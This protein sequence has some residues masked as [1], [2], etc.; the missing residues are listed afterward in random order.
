MAISEAQLETWS[1][2][3][4]VTTAKATADSV[5]NAIDSYREWEWSDKL[6]FEVYLQ[7]S[8]KNNTNIRADS[9]V[10]VVAQLNTAF[11]SNLSDE[12]KR[13]LGLPK[14]TYSWCEFKEDVLKALKD[15]YGST[16]ISEGD[17]SIKLKQNNGRL[18]ADIIVS[19]Q[20]RNYINVDRSEYIV[21]ICFWPLTSN[22][23]IINYPKAHYENG[24]NKN[25]NCNN[26]YKSLVRMF[27][28]MRNYISNDNTP[29]YFLECLIYNVP[30]SK[31]GGSYQDSFCNIVNWLSKADFNNFICQNEKIYLFDLCGE[32]W[33]ALKA[34][35]FV[36]NLVMVWNNW[37]N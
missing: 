12:Q 16:F 4:A 9:D 17:K 29:S 20:Y 31:F 6:D 24:V 10:D 14:A 26:W 37:G 11:Y 27:K 25:R 5:K 22:R 34:K 33:D 2:Q 1:H 13:Q 3:G 23:Q 32:Q 35:T 8:Y 28:N 18:P 19:C 21:G 15:Y 7:G 36:N 30:N